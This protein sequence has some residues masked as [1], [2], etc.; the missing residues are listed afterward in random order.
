M[1]CRVGGVP[2]VVGQ[3]VYFTPYGTLYFVICMICMDA[4][5]RFLSRK[6]ILIQR[7]GVMRY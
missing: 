2:G 6:L 1:V 5:C 7:Q 3:Q 4:F